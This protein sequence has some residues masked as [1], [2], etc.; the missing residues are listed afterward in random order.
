[1]IIYYD[2][3]KFNFLLSKLLISPIASHKPKTYGQ[4]LDQYEEQSRAWPLM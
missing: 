3:Y 2:I 1:M 4:I